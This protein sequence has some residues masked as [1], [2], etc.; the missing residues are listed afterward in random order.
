MSGR[1]KINPCKLKGTSGDL[2]NYGYETDKALGPPK[3]GCEMWEQCGGKYL[4]RQKGVDDRAWVGCQKLEEMLLEEKEANHPTD[5][6][7][8]FEDSKTETPC[9]PFKVP[10]FKELI[11]D[12]KI[13][14]QLKLSLQMDPE[15]LETMYTGPSNINPPPVTELL[16][17]KPDNA[18]LTFLKYLYDSG[19]FSGDPLLSITAHL[20]LT[21]L[22]TDPE[23]IRK[24]FPFY[25]QSLFASYQSK[26]NAI[27]DK[28]AAD[29]TGKHPNKTLWY[30]KF[31][32][33]LKTLSPKQRHAINKYY[34]RNL[35]KL[36]KKEIA[37]KLNISQ[38][39]FQDRLNGAI[40]KLK[41][42]FPELVTKPAP[43]P[44]TEPKRKQSPKD[45]SIIDAWFLLTT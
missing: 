35:D 1:R 41:A 33:Y 9:R 45:L 30:K 16:K 29:K 24:L 31:E 8:K 34:M 44:Q 37:K 18:K 11:E 15:A 27:L 23:A 38:A 40:K 39:S 43:K 28:E 2:Y 6:T 19:Y 3:S 4:E 32:A 25:P 21:D 36:S 14:A 42:M 22:K 17:A 26:V 10:K 5:Q 12:P 7:L 13:E 20:I